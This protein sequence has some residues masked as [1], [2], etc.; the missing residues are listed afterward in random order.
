MVTVG[1]TQAEEALE[2]IEYSLA[3]SERRAPDIEKRASPNM[4][5][6]AFGGK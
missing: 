5:Q 6:D 4:N 2:D 1:C 3:A